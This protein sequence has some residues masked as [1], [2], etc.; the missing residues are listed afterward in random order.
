MHNVLLDQFLLG[1]AQVEML[2]LGLEHI[3]GFFALPLICLDLLVAPLDVSLRI[4][5]L[6]L[7]RLG[8]VVRATFLFLGSRSG[9][10]LWLLLFHCLLLLWLLLLLSSAISINSTCVLVSCCVGRGAYSSL[11][12]FPSFEPPY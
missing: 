12:W 1:L 11:T 2:H 10:L 3:P 7:H 4:L 8:D 9:R 5:S 6:L